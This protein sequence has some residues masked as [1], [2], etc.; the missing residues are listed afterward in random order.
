[1]DL[2]PQRHQGLEGHQGK[3]PF[4]VLRGLCGFVVIAALLPLAGCQQQRD[5]NTVVVPIESHPANLD[6]RIGTDAQSE[7]IGQLLFD[8]LLERDRNFQLRPALAERWESPDPL[9]YRFHIRHGVRFHD[10]RPLTARDCAYTLRSIRDGT[11]PTV[12]AATFRLVQSIE[13][14]DDY[15][16]LVRLS[17][18]Y[19]SFLWSLTQGA[20]GIV[21]EGA[22]K[23]FGARPIGTG[24]FRFVRQAQDEEVVLERNRD[25]W[26]GSG[27]DAAAPG[28]PVER[29]QF[30]VVPDATVRALELRKGAADVALNSLSADM[31]LALRR[32]KH[33]RV[34]AEP[35]T[36]YQYLALNLSDPVLRRKEVR[37]A[38]AYG[39]DTEPIIRYVWRGMARPAASMLPPNHWAYDGALRPISYDP[40]KAARLLDQAGFRP[41]RHGVRLRLGIKTSTEETSRQLAAILQQQWRQIG[42][43]LDVRSYEFATFYA[44]IVKGAFQIYTLRWIGANND[45]DIFEYCFHSRKFP[46]SG[47]NRGHYSSA[48]A[49]RLIDLARKESGQGKRREYYARLQELL[50]DDLPYIHLWYFDNVAVLDQRLSGMTLLPGGDYDFLK[51]LCL[52][53]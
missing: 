16:L 44:D 48:E 43:A 19:A 14:P 33:L 24:A 36:I 23:D 17:E 49:D 35:G 2:E 21:P 29:V 45:P 53:P 11:V 12:K 42:L 30:K 6:P 20:I 8:G 47:A 46:P 25:C 41:D 50:N 1:M 5:P 28:R 37:Q 51:T 40:A 3:A 52:K 31:V 39:T 27:G 4:C 9:T 13:T 32:E 34:M 18:P 10:G 15:T 22:G 38:L 26:N 7:R